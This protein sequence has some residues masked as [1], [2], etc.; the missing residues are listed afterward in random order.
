MTEKDKVQQ[1][2]KEVGAWSRKTT[3]QLKSNIRR[4]TSTSTE[5]VKDKAK[6]TSLLQS[7]GVRMQRTY[8]E[9]D[10]ITFQFHRHGIF[11][12][13]GVGRGYSRVN[14]VVVRGKKVKIGKNKNDSRTDF[15]SISGIIQ[16]RPKDW[17]TTTM[18]KNFEELSD[19]IGEN[20][21]DRSVNAAAMRIN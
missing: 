13:H 11:L 16:R 17:L 5:D 7:L 9:I 1:L 21:A 2:N 10:R 3:N 6:R 4:L 14:K 20:Y 12:Q 8:G 15:K 19:Q 18:N